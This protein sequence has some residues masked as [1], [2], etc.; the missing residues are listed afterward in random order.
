VSTAVVSSAK[1]KVQ[2]TLPVIAML[3]ISQSIVRM[4]VYD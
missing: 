4:Y 2:F 3:S 1:H